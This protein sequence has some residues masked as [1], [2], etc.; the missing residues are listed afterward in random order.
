VLLVMLT[1]LASAGI[2]V[3]AGDGEASGPRARPDLVVASREESSEAPGHTV[4][5]VNLTRVPRSPRPRI[6]SVPP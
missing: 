1:A 2:D 5:N 4:G 3:F 6:S